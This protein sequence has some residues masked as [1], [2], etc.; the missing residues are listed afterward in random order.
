MYEC[1]ILFAISENLR[2]FE[3]KIIHSSESVGNDIFH[4]YYGI[5]IWEKI[6]CCNFNPAIS[7]LQWLPGALSSSNI[8]IRVNSMPCKNTDKR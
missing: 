8:V 7:D 1:K 2:L 3:G 6:Q 4:L 5:F